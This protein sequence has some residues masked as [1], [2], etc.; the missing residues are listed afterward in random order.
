MEEWRKNY[1][2]EK[3]EREKQLFPNKVE[4]DLEAARKQELELA[5]QIEKEQASTVE[6]ELRLAAK[7][8]EERIKAAN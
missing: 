4:Q 2:K 6:G 1:E 3:K 5:K 8:E 7:I